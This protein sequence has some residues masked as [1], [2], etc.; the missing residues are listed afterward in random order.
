MTMT[1][2][3]A[4]AGA[5]SAAG[6]M[7]LAGLVRVLKRRG[8][9][10]AVTT[11][12]G[13]VLAVVYLLT[14]SPTYTSSSVLYIN[15]SPN[16]VVNENAPAPSSTGADLAIV[17]SQ[18][19]I[20]GSDAM[21]RRVVDTLS[22]DQDGEF[23]GT[24]PLTR[25]RNLISGGTDADSPKAL[26]AAKLAKRLKILRAQKTYIVEVE[27]SASTP[28]KAAQ[29]TDTLVSLYLAD[30]AAA[31]AEDERRANELI[32]GRLGELREQVRQAEDRVDDFK[33]RNRITVSEGSVLDEQ[34]LGKLNGELVAA[35]AS[36][37]EAKGRL[38]AVRAA[39]TSDA[40]LEAMPEAVRSPTIQRLREQH[41]QVARRVA[42]LSSQLKGRHPV[43]IEARSQLAEI[44]GQI[45]DELRRIAG[46]ASADHE[47]AAN[48]ER[49]LT[50]VL[51]TSK[52]D[53]SRTSTAQIKLRELEQDVGTSREV[54]G[55]FL[56]RAKETREQEQISVPYA[57]V[58]SPAT[59]PPQPSWPI[60]W[61]VLGLGG[62]L[63][64]GVGLVRA[65][66]AEQL[67]TSLS[68]APRSAAL[69]G[70]AV[71]PLP[72][73]TRAGAAG[74]ALRPR[75]SAPLVSK[76][77]TPKAFARAVEAISKPRDS[78]ASAYQQGVLHILAALASERHDNYPSAI[79]LVGAEAQ[80]GLSTTALAIAHAAVQRSE[81]VLLIDA[82]S[83]NPELTSLLAPDANGTWATLLAK[84]EA[85]AQHTVLDTESKLAFLPLAKADL[86]LLSSTERRQLAAN[87]AASSLDY[88]L[89]L[90]DGGALALD[91][92]TSAL[93]PLADTIA[94]VARNNATPA[95]RLAHVSD[96]LQPME[97][98]VAGIILVGVEGVGV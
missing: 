83:S 34:Q 72:P 94:I 18:V 93:L 42:S 80:A 17:D 29:I 69:A 61:L 82:N 53:V 8:R 66:S 27:V 10:I 39:A 86:R 98:K 84:P 35:R 31:R 92:S 38:D 77:V 91:E 55:M 85:L 95:G 52:A 54:L 71:Y 3:Y 12:A 16:R 22:L 19:S 50:R 4:I 96:L 15:P 2:T 88:D 33:R 40:A 46:A 67:D 41:A 44:R 73:L 9:Q 28:A 6:T 81:R 97:D 13:L 26:A 64:L 5:E 58:V 89:V 23:S 14:T 49:E 7:D 57:R 21:L 68:Y 45:D 74:F 65:L 30:Q 25:L 90:I 51:E 63:G 59:S 11:L 70:F 37:A 1:T 62:F 87:V 20:I 75:S 76:A 36:A 48:R 24:G 43:L 79:L 60:G 47:I 56:Q 78:A 32:N